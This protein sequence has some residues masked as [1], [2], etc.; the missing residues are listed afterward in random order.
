MLR[1]TICGVL[2]A[3]LAACGGDY[4]RRSAGSAAVGTDATTGQPNL[5]ARSALNRN[6]YIGADPNFPESGTSGRR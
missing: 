4:Y 2:L 5:T 6:Y 3:S 1:L